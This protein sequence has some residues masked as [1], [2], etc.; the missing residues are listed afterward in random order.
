[1]QSIAINNAIRDSSIGGI[2]MSTG[3][4]SCKDYGDCGIGSIS[5][6]STECI[7]FRWNGKT[8]DS[9]KIKFSV[10]NNMTVLGYKTS[11]GFRT[12]TALPIE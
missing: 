2:W 12:L 6:C 1:M 10:G 8:P 5:K 3:E 7:N 4:R 9:L 11:K